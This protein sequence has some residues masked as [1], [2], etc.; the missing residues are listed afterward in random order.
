[1]EKLSVYK[2]SMTENEC[3]EM[4]VDNCRKLLSAIGKEVTKEK[5]SKNKKD[6]SCAGSMNHV[7]E[8][9]ENAYRFIANINDN[10]EL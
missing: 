10:E 5:N 3:F 2:A 8:I 4:R 9:L 6:W 7:Q 1:M